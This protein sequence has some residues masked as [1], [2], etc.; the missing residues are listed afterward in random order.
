MSK[1]QSPHPKFTGK[2]YVA[3]AQKE[4]ELQRRILLGLGGI[5][6][7]IIFVILIGFLRVY[8]FIPRQPVAVVEGVEISTDD[9][10]K[11]VLYEQ[12][13]LD[14]Q[15][16]N[17]GTQY[18][19]IQQAFAD[20]PQL[21]S[22]LQNQTGQQMQQLL[23]QRQEIDRLALEMLIEEELVA[24][25]AA[26]RGIEVSEDEVTGAIQ[27]RAAI[28]E[29]GYTEPDAQAT[30]T[31]RFSAAQDATATAALFTPTPTLTPTAIL[32]STT[33]TTTTEEVPAP[34]PTNP[35]LPTPTIN[36]LRGDALT[37][38]VTNWENTLRENA[39]MTP[40]DFRSLVRRGLLQEKVQEA[41]G[42]EVDT[43]APQAHARH[44]LVETEEEALAIKER[45]EAGETFEDLA[46]ELTTDPGSGQGGGDLG[47]FTE[48]DMV[49]PFAEAAFTLEIGEI[50]DPVETQFGWH[51]IEVLEREEREVEG[52]ALLRFQRNAYDAWLAGARAGNIEDR[53]TPDSPPPLA[54]DPPS[55]QSLI[56]DGDG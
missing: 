33:E 41:I 45:L 5:G 15:L 20:N 42:S 26:R 49:T 30:V 25:E 43:V 29:S 14:D 6:A 53:W 4:A 12:F 8:V 24:Q 55:L 31:A 2:K 38:T 52:A 10:R 18:N 37:Q 21:L 35:P 47:W 34:L 11:R 19:Q 13:L 54:K 48:E 39:N 1:T 28:R 17:L 32:T 56:G 46:A 36:V 44:I 50:S 23:L 27:A 22:S 40:E 16:L 51:I 3:R 9:Y 7:L